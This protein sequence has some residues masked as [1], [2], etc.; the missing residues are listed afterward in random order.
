LC[1]AAQDEVDYNIRGISPK[2]RCMTREFATFPED[3]FDGVA[4]RIPGRTSV[5][6]NYAMTLLDQ[7]SRHMLSNEARSANQQIRH[8][9]TSSS[10]W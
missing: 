4:E 6:R 9:V 1:F 8:L 7:C 2:F 5:I 10:S 3:V